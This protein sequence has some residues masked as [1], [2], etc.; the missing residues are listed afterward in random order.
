MDRQY[1]GPNVSGESRWV[2]DGIE[3]WVGGIGDTE[4]ATF[5]TKTEALLWRAAP[6]MLATLRR[7]EADLTHL[8]ARGEPLKSIR[9]AIAK[10]EGRE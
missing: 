5:A 1:S 8:G 10:A 3:G 7:V 6:D 9:K 4:V 2:S